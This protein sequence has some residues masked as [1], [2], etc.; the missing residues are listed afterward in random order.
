MDQLPCM[1]IDGEQSNCFC[2]KPIYILLNSFCRITIA[3]LN[4]QFCYSFYIVW[5]CML[6]INLSNSSSL[7]SRRG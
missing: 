7:V 6:E 4:N 1:E 2:E 5:I 3:I